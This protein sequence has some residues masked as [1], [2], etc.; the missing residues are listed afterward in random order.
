MAK[1]FSQKQLLKC[2][3]AAEGMAGVGHATAHARRV[4]QFAAR[5]SQPQGR[6]KGDV[7]YML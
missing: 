1:R 5:R 4:A 2:G 6:R 3:S 7:W